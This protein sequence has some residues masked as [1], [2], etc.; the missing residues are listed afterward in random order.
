MHLTQEWVDRVSRE[1]DDF[2]GVIGLGIMNTAEVQDMVA[3]IDFKGD[4]WQLI[5]EAAQINKKNGLWYM[6]YRVAA[7][8]KELSSYE[9]IWF[10]IFTEWWS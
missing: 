4:Y 2:T 10:E 8:P 6:F 5:P 1:P 9:I 3:L 7:G